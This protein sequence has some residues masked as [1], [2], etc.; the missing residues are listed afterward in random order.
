MW[1]RGV[2][3]SQKARVTWEESEMISNCHEFLQQQEQQIGINLWLKKVKPEVFHF[4][5]R[6]YKAVIFFNFMFRSPHCCSLRS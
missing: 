1:G 2:W 5:N 6:F 4:W 3:F